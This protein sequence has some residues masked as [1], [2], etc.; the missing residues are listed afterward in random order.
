MSQYQDEY[1]RLRP[2]VAKSVI[3][4]AT[5]DNVNKQSH[6]LRLHGIQLQLRGINKDNSSHLLR[7]QAQTVVHGTHGP[8][9]K[10]IHGKDTEVLVKAI[11]QYRLDDFV[12]VGYRYNGYYYFLLPLHN[13]CLATLWRYTI[14][15]VLCLV[16]LC[17]APTGKDGPQDAFYN[18]H[19]N[20]NILVL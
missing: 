20:S 7:H 2:Q 9:T 15:T 16:V 11:H 18:H 13:S 4:M 1:Q 5:Y 3:L 17:K 19:G 6:Q 12:C 10:T 14:L 8:T